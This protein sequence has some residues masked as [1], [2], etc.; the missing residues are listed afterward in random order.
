MEYK[1]YYKPNRNIEPHKDPK[2]NK[3]AFTILKSME[4]KL[5]ELCVPEKFKKNWKNVSLYHPKGDVE[6]ANSLLL[7]PRAHQCTER[8]VWTTRSRG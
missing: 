8:S 3:R 6:K 1:F 5:D 7:D 4:S 2:V